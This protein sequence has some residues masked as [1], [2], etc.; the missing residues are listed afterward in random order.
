MTTTSQPLSLEIHDAV[1]H[2][3]HLNHRQMHIKQNA[4][5]VTIHG[6][7]RSFFEK[8]MAQEALRNIQGVK[9]IENQL[10]VEWT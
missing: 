5:R 6:T 10:Q 3:P 7:V 4:G 1:I 2:N 8:Q 9:E